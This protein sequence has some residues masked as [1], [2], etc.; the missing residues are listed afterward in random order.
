MKMHQEAN[1][2]EKETLAELND[3]TNKYKSLFLRHAEEM[4]TK[5]PESPMYDKIRYEISQIDVIE[6]MW[7]A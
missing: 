3:L 4:K 7:E 1:K 6:Q 2:F 5:I